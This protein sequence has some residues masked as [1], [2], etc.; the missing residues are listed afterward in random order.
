[1]T[2][3]VRVRPEEIKRFREQTGLTQEGLA[4][5]LQKSLTTVQRYEQRGAA[6]SF[7]YTLLGLAMRELGCEPSTLDLW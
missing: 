5:W 7:R 1:M 6:P 4:R 3:L 2:P